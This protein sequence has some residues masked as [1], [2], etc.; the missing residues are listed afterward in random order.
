MDADSLRIRRAE[1]GCRRVGWE[2]VA[3]P[4]TPER[5]GGGRPDE[6][7]S[8]QLFSNSAQP[9]GLML[10]GQFMFPNPKDTPARFPQCPRHEPVTNLIAGNLF[11]PESGI[12]L[13]LGSVL[14]AAMPETAVKKQCEPHLPE[15]KIRPHSEFLLS[16]PSLA[17]G[18]GRGWP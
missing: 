2:K 15:N 10:A 17:R 6:G 18:G 4:V 9:A 11:A 14:G 12:T 3:G 13:G 5:S 8:S 7:K 1:I 16:A